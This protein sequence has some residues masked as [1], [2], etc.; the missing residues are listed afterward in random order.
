MALVAIAALATGAF[1]T[2]QPVATIA[3]VAI[4]GASAL[5]SHRSRGPA[6]DASGTPRHGWIALAWAFVLLVPGQKFSAARDP[7]AAAQGSASLGDL[8][9]L[10]VY[11]AIAVGAL[12]SLRR[13]SAELVRLWPLAILPALGLLSASWSLAPVLTLARVFE[14][15]A[16]VL[17]AALTAG[18]TV[19]A[20]QGAAS[21]AMAALRIFVLVI[22]V[23]CVVGLVVGDAGTLTAT[24]R[25]AGRFAWPGAHPVLASAYAGAALLTVAFGGRRGLHLAMPL[26]L[27]L[28]L[29]FATC[30]YLGETRMA[31][32]GVT[33]SVFV[34]LIA[35]GRRLYWR[36]VGVA[37]VTAIV[38]LALGVA[39]PTISDYLSRG[40]SQQQVNSLNGR[41]PL[42][43]VAGDQ[44]DSP[45]R[46]VVGYGLG[47]SRT[48]LLPQASW[49]GGAHSAWIELLLSLGLVGV[50]AGVAVVLTVGA[51]LWRARARGRVDTHLLTVL[52]A[53]SLILSLVADGLGIPG[54]GPSF[55]FSLLA[56]SYATVAVPR[57]ERGVQPIRRRVEHDRHSRWRSPHPPLGPAVGTATRSSR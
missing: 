55:G 1:L 52:F 4:F 39:G 32:L 12:V 9:E 3:C 7:L 53:Y 47:A 43:Q 54:P 2:W 44:I 16:V 17:L 5:F 14:M 56:L 21:A 13:V 28:I 48:V 36:L 42:W 23:L 57:R 22:A 26:R 38:V 33:G 50:A 45:Q 41:I 34:A 35:S 19:R 51:R 37:A 49:A 18:V 30:L 11:A 8:T 29:L 20:P 25:A 24:Q 40:E 15:M 10:F 46:W 6:A 31:L 27:A